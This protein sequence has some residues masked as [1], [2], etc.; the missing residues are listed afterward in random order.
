MWL[1]SSA[2]QMINTGPLHIFISSK[3]IFLLLN[4]SSLQKLQADIQVAEGNED[5]HLQIL[6]EAENIL[7]S[8]KSDLVRLKDQVSRIGGTAFLTHTLK[9]KSPKMP[10]PRV[11]FMRR[12]E[13]LFTDQRE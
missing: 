7:R 6:K 2:I 1:T 12:A 10:D 9:C 5:H 11:A 3:N 13:V 4:F 8:K